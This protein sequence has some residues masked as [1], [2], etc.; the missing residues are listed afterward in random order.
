[1]STLQNDPV[2]TAL[3][4]WGEDAP[5]W[6]VALA[7]ACQSASQSRVAERIGRSPTVVSQV[8]RAKYPGDLRAVAD[9]VR[10]ALMSG[11]VE[12]P[13]LGLLPTH[14]CRGWMARA[15]TFGNTNALRVRMYRACRA[16]SRFSKGGEE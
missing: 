14:E 1:M 7:E 15:R 9:L 11:T 8:L 12:C 4:H 2:A 6:I 5:D 3:L 10:G 13:A 16:C